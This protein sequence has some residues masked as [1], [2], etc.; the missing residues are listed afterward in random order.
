MNRKSQINVFRGVGFRVVKKE[1]TAGGEGFYYVVSAGQPCQVRG[2]GH[3]SMEISVRP[4][5]GP[6]NT[7]RMEQDGFF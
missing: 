5:L 4:C 2:W 6:I 3:H 7:E 1:V